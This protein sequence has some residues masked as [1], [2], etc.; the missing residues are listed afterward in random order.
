MRGRAAIAVLIGALIAVT[1]LA[2]CGGGDGD[3]TSEITKAQFI[4]RADAICQKANEDKQQAIAASFKKRSLTSLPENKKVQEEIVLEAI[5]PLKKMTKELG[6]LG[7]PSGDEK[8]VESMVDS[9]EAGI[10]SI[11][12]DPAGA[13]GESYDAFDKANQMAAAYGLEAC[14]NV[15]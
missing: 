15:S 14:E 8:K 1:A 2:G 5:P 11:E 10:E 4:N 6:A 9:Y 3:E 12:E 13:L 7:A